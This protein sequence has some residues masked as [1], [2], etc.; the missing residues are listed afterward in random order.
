MTIAG[1]G[2]TV[3]LGLALVYPHR[4]LE[5]RL[6]AAD[7]AAGSG[8]L[9]IEYLKVFVKA[10]PSA[11]DMRLQLAKKLAQIG[12]VDGAERMLDVPAARQD[13]A[14]RQ[15]APWIRLA[16]AETRYY[17]A[18]PDSPARAAAQRDIHRR[19]AELLDQ[20]LGPQRLAIV[21]S[22]ALADAEPELARIAFARLAAA[23]AA[24]T[25]QAYQDAA[26]GALGV[27]DYAASA[28]LEFL[29]MDRSSELGDKR[30]HFLGA[31]RTLQS[32]GLLQQALDEAER[33]L[34]PRSFLAADT[35]VL[36]FLARLARSANRP[37]IAERYA[38]R[39]L[40]LTLLERMH[41]WERMRLVAWH[42]ERPAAPESGARAM[43]IADTSPAGP[44]LP[45]DEDA[46]RLG[47]DIFLSNRNLADALRVAQSAVRQRPQSAPWQRR[48]AEVSEWSGAP[49]EA[50][51]HWLAHARMT[52]EEAS[53]D[54][55]LRLSDS[56]FDQPALREALE[57][58]LAREPQQLT[59]L[60]RLLALDELTGQPQRAIARL[61]QRLANRAALPAAERER[62]MA[63]LAGIEE[64]AGRDA[65]ALATTERLQRE[66]GPRTGYAL[67]IAN[68]HFRR[69]EFA[70]GFEALE[71]ARGVAAADDALYWRNYAELARLLGKDAA[72]E[73]GYRALIA[74]GLQTGADAS[75]LVALWAHD[76]PRAA[77]A[78]AADAY[79]RGGEPALAEQ[80]LSLW[81][82]V[83]ERGEARAFL[84]RLS[85]AQREALSARPGFL[86]LRAA[87]KQS[88]EDLAGARDDLR[89][90][91][92]REPA[93]AEARAALVWVLIALRDTEPLKE[94][95]QRWSADAARTPA[96]WEAFAAAAM[97]LNRQDEAL[98]WFAK[99]D[100]KSRSGDVLWLMAYAECLEANSRP[101]IAWRLRRQAWNTLRDPQ[102]L[103]RLRPGQVEA[104]RERLASL[105]PLFAGGDD[106]WRV[107]Q[108][109]LRADAKQIAAPRQPAPPAQSPRELLERLDQQA[110]ARPTPSRAGVT[111]AA[112]LLAAGTQ[113]DDGRL[114][115]GARELALSY[116][117]NADGN[118]LAR[119]WLAA[120]Y[121]GQLARPLYAELSL[122][123]QDDDRASLDRLLD[124]LPDWLPMYD[125][126]DAARRAQRPA[127][128]QTLAFDQ[129]SR[130]PD[131]EQL[132]ARLVELATENGPKLS[133]QT[134]HRSES[135][136]V[137]TETKIEAAA[138]AT[139]GLRFS[140]EL[141][142]RRQRSDDA[143][144]LLAPPP[145]DR[146]IALTVTR[147]LDAGSVSATLQRRDALAGT[148]G[149]KLSAQVSPLRDLQLSGAIGVNQAAIESVPLMVG[150]MRHLAEISATYALSGRAY[151]RTD[152]G[153]Q[154]FLSQG[155]AA[156]GSGRSWRFEAGERL[157]IDYPDLTLSAYL[158]GNRFAASGDFDARIAGLLPAG[159]DPAA[160]L[161]P[162]GSRT[163]GMLLS[164]ENAETGYHRAWR[165][166]GALGVSYNTVTGHGY[167]LRA[168]AAGSV[169]GGDMLRFYLDRTAATPAAQQGSREIG[170]RYDAFY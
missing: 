3:G 54:A 91:L 50:L 63:L 162:Q 80:A 78:L 136:L 130:L 144:Q 36:K 169:L 159:A 161:L 5:H 93:N 97:S 81:S 160:T 31:L 90:A 33:H 57:H 100:L 166:F 24:L 20:R 53:W 145:H 37:D 150:G 13:A 26:R 28:Q 15:E 35:G 103:A 51:T 95:L 42:G 137:Y 49:Q 146:R 14:L 21:G 34:G 12:D 38:K 104:M 124:T 1:F 65:D 83:S 139:P 121:A 55:V 25:A 142:E 117:L 32:G 148:S 29:A 157:R 23:P 71:S 40:E 88:G 85:P 11:G 167:E 107:V 155:G 105:A 70:A 96:L 164:S 68:L 56:L 82:S 2:L 94:A 22:H 46:Y 62:E 6:A 17:A 116:A 59:W 158:M 74:A 151:L 92:A 165:P 52:N 77:A 156:L 120:R 114:A 125:R 101:D 41:E 76:R 61:E 147:S 87:L 127:L 149:A 126:I 106:A 141:S 153:W 119:A 69:G 4:A 86:I 75:N 58:K 10:D 113:T 30:A 170:L 99:F 47:Y 131:D 134:V 118:D 7:S 84:A 44:G 102:A 66:F 128:A 143:A 132:H 140:M 129:L 39:F 45:F 89:A 16:L 135:P 72:A 110:E 154:R 9:A 111:D 152:L 109:L 73:R 163:V 19:L 60:N 67:K 98:R 122:A 8:A 133:A 27:G 168:G 115:A 123:L 138:Q 43:R 48:L 64:R 108:V 112:S 79:L 18:P